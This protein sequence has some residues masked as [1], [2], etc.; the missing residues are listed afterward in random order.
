MQR[1]VSQ[2]HGQKRPRRRRSKARFPDRSEKRG[3]AFLKLG[4]QLN[5][6]R[7]PKDAAAI[8]LAIADELFPWDS[9]IFDL[10]SPDQSKV[11]TI[12]CV[13]TINGSRIE[14]APEL[15]SEKLSPAARK[16]MNKSELILRPAGAGFPLESNP[17]GDKTHASSS[18]MY[19]PLKNDNRVIGFLSFQSYALDAYTQDDLNTLEAL[20]DHCG[21][22]LERIRAEEEIIRL[23]Q[24]LRHGLEESQALFEVAP[25]GI[26]VAH[27]PECSIVTGNPAFTNLLGIAPGTNASTLSPQ[28]DQLPFTITRN[29]EPIDPQELPMRR[30]SRDGVS[31]REELEINRSDGRVLHIYIA[32]APLYDENGHVRGSV[33]MLVDLTERKQAEAEA[34]RLNQE[35]EARVRERTAQLEA[36]NKELETF[37]YS[38]SHDLRAPLRSIRGFSEVLLERYG[39]QLDARGQ[40]FLR[41]T[42]QS[43]HHM[44]KLIDD[45]LKL[46]RVGRSEIQRRTVN[47]TEL[48]SNIAAEL[49]K[50][51]PERVADFVIAPGIEAQGDE[52]LL[53]VALDNLVRNAWKFTNRLP[54]ARIEFGVT[55]QPELAYFVRDNGA[56]FDMDYASRLFGVF[57]RL[58]AASEFPGTGVGLATVQRI[59]NRHGGHAWAFSKL[60]EGA[61]F[62]FTLPTHDASAS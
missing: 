14:F 53:R 31:I 56:G 26:A 60:N 51:E 61:T 2:K 40:D 7:T 58:H 41:R 24:E 17:F 6:V 33:G 11:K 54:R 20:A 45:L 35:L 36:I 49:R 30:A 52:R 19:A 34:R 37:S 22:A 48:V 8:I 46:S 47:L 29:G 42:C 59:I 9:C 23:N 43:S 18:L 12:I 27:D 5:A 28:A 3:L 62:Y 16:R 39:P 4:R 15:C 38:V 25:V 10:V 57:Q 13:D 21:G 50:T 32:A 55:D 44:D 1:S